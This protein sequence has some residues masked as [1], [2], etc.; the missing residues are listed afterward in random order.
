MRKNFLNLIIFVSII[1]IVILTVRDYFLVE[2]SNITKNKNIF[3]PT[4]PITPSPTKD[5]NP[6]IPCQ[7]KFFNFKKGTIWQYKLISEIELN[8]EKQTLDTFF[9]NKIIEAS[10]SSIIIETQFK[11]EKEKAVSTLV[12][13][14]NGIYGFPFLLVP[15]SLLESFPLLSQFINFIKSDESI[16]LL[17]SEEKLKKGEEWPTIS[18]AGFGILLNSKITNEVKQSVLD[19]GYIETLIVQSQLKFDQSFLKQIDLTK[20]SINYQLGE[21]VGFLN[22]DLNLNLELLGKIKLSFKLIDFNP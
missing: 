19:L 14:K 8:K 15:N 1:G 20:Q 11:G 6:K 2:R 13:R 4:Q 17:P 18:L 10:G 22:L 5:S 12:C 7:N 9:T 3:I 21:N 16:L